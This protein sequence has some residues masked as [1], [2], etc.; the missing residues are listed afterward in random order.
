MS[1]Q[2]PYAAA[3]ALWGA[4][5]ARAGAQ[6]DSE[7]RGMDA[8][9]VRRALGVAS[10]LQQGPGALPLACRSVAVCVFNIPLAVQDPENDAYLA[11]K[12][13]GAFGEW[14]GTAEHHFLSQQ[15]KQCY[16]STAELVEGAIGMPRA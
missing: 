15:E 16:D 10:L 11:G 3:A 1:D 2:N 9:Y 13:L 8:E 4:V 5:L 14:L 12:L 7:E 6:T